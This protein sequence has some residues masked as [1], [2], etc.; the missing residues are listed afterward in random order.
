MVIMKILTVLIKTGDHIHF[1]SV[2]L[3]DPGPCVSVICVICV[4]SCF[5][6]LI[7]LR[8]TQ[9]HTQRTFQFKSLL[10]IPVTCNIQVSEVS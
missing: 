2:S 6:F 1:V 5:W 10:V 7:S 3:S 4:I 8:P 9:T